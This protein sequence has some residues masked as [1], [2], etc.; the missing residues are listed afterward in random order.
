MSVVENAILQKDDFFAES[1]VIHN[2]N[3]GPRE[4]SPKQEVIREGVKKTFNTIDDKTCTKVYQLISNA[5]RACP[6]TTKAYQS[7]M[8]LPC[9]DIT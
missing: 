6:F 3:R 4:I 5:F 9:K 1:Y 7:S 2:R 8:N